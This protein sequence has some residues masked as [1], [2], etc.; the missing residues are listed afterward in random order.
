L[1]FHLTSPQPEWLSR[2]QQAGDPSQ[3]PKFKTQYYQKRKQTTNASEDRGQER[4]PH[5]LLMEMQTNTA[6]MEISMEVP[7]KT[8][9]GIDI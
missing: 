8:K 9:N 1:R 3:G 4:N 6:T 7:Q 2:R 5:T